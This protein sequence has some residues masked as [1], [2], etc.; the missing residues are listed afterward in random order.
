M[1][2]RR[3]ITG[4]AAVLGA[5]LLGGAHI[6]SAARR[7]IS[8]ISSRLSRTARRPITEAS[9]SDLNAGVAALIAIGRLGRLQP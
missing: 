3:L 6:A 5:L 8:L 4:A 9:P 7:R 2:P 1:S